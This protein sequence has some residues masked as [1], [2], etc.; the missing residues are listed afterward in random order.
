MPMPDEPFLNFARWYDPIFEN[1]LG[2]LR[3]LV[4]RLAPPR[5]GMKILD[6]GCGTGAQ[7]D[8]YHAAGCQVC[9]IDLAQPMIRVAKSKLGEGAVLSVGDAL[10]IPHPD[11]AFDLVIS[12]LFIHQLQPGL[13]AAML[14]EAGRVLKSEGQILLVDFHVQAKRSLLGK[15]TYAFIS[16][17]E[18]FAGWEHFSTSRDFLAKGGIPTL[19]S[20]LELGIRKSI[21]V[22][23][24]NLG[25]YLLQQAD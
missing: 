17:I 23:N 8:I 5:D 13:R 18:F 9:G 22:G 21:I 16:V 25:V 6:I 3:A 11:Q 24:G 7:L 20:G 4:A 10:R 1:L 2:G 14:E 19:A 15:L 12:S